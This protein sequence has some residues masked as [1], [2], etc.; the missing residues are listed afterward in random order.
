MDCFISISPISTSNALT[1]DNI[2]L[3]H[4]MVWILINH[5][6]HFLSSYVS[7]CKKQASN[8]TVKLLKSRYIFI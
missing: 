1:N 7:G 8:N 2:G 5:K 6:H 4:C 3:D